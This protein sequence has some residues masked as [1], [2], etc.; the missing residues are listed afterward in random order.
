MLPY[1]AGSAQMDTVDSLLRDRDEVL[2]KVREWLLQEQQ[3]SKKYYDASHRDREYA[4][5]DWV[6]LRLLHHTAQSLEPQAKGRLGPRYAG[7]FQV[8]ERIG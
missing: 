3:L 7:S 1:K 4:V 2:A 6:W 5:R 8:L